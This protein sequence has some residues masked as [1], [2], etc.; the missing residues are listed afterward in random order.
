[1]TELHVLSLP[2]RWAD[3]C[4]RTTEPIRC[5]FRAGRTWLWD[6]RA[7]LLLRPHEDDANRLR[8][9]SMGERRSGEKLLRRTTVT[10][11]CLSSPLPLLRRMS[12]MSLM[13]RRRGPPL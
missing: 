5:V 10:V 4:R 13:M 7:G 8:P 2:T 9:Y 1:M 12:P 11:T 3:A 6:I